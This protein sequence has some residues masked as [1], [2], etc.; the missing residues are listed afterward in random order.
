MRDAPGFDVLIETSDVQVTIVLRDGMHVC[1]LTLAKDGEVIS[2]WTSGVPVTVEEAALGLGLA[3]AF[4]TGAGS[5]AGT[6]F[7][8]LLGIAGGTGIP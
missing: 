1:D 8:G 5:L 3:A 2:S 6:L 7:E 4:G